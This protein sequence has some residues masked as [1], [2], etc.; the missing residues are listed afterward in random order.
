MKL[1]YRVVRSLT[2]LLFKLLYHHR[3]F[4]IRNIT[5]GRAI[6]APNHASFLDPPLVAV[7]WP[8]EISFLA[9]KSL[10]SPLLGAIIKKLNAYPV[11]GTTQDLG[12]I[13][14]I[15]SLLNQDK[16]VVIFPEGFRTGD[17]AMGD[18]KSGICMLAQRCQA[19]IIP[20]YIDGSFDAW[21]RSRRFPK[22]KG[23]TACVI[24]TPIGWDQFKHLDKK[25]AQEAAA[26]KVKEALISLKAWYENG[27]IG[28]PP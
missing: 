21:D 5:P 28:Q 6:I 17:G 9:R 27:A 10:F 8:E 15:C 19:P 7:S 26:I 23:K 11:T 13:K 12:S 4:G 2:S 3:T 25:A 18:I 14:L 16:K 24:G 20:V 22:L 1:F